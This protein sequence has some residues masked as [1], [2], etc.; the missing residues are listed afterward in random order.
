MGSSLTAAKWPVSIE[1]RPA[2]KFKHEF[3]AFLAGIGFQLKHFLPDDNVG[4][5]MFT[6]CLIPRATGYEKLRGEGGLSE[7]LALQWARR[8]EHFLQEALKKGHAV[9]LDASVSS[10]TKAASRRS[11]GES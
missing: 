7:G 10:T 4:E 6:N 1:M 11:I 3:K 8:S 9:Q 5:K 2:T